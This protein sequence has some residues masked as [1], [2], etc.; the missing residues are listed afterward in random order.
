[1]STARTLS[2]AEPCA[3]LV[4]DNRQDATVDLALG[5]N[6]DNLRLKANTRALLEELNQ[7]AL[8]HPEAQGGL[9]ANPVAQPDLDPTQ[10]AAARQVSCT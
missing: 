9:Q 4:K 1:M 10:L 2:L 8:Q 6:F 7:W 3:Q 5:K